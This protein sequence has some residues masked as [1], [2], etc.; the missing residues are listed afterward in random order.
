MP[1]RSASCL[2]KLCIFPCLLEE[3]IVGK[4][5]TKETLG[6]DAVLILNSSMKFRSSRAVIWHLLGHGIHLEGP[7]GYS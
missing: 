4:Y 6:E 5:C 3:D 2:P 1:R 7:Q